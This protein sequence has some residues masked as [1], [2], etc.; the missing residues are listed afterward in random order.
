MANTPNMPQYR[1]QLRDHALIPLAELPRIGGYLDGDVLLNMNDVGAFVLTIKADQSYTIPRNLLTAQQSDIEAGPLGD[2]DFKQN[3][4]VGGSIAV[5]T[6]QAWHGASS[7]KVIT[8]GASTFQSVSVNLPTSAFVAG[9]VYTFSGYLK[10]SSGTPTL[11][12]YCQANDLIA[13]NTSIGTVGAIVLSTTWTRYTFTVTLPADLSPYSIIGLRAD[14]GGT[15]QALTWWL[16]GL[17]VERASSASGWA[18]GGALIE[19]P[20][21]QYFAAGNGVIISRD[22]GDGSGAQTILSGPIWHLERRLQDNVYVLAGPDDMWSL[23]ARRAEPVTS[24]SYPAAVLTLSGLLRYYKLGES[25]GTAA[26]DSKSA[27]SGTYTGGFTLGQSAIADDV[28]TSVLFNGT[29]GYVNAA[30]TSLPTGNAAMFMGVWCY[31]ASAPAGNVAPIWYGNTTEGTR[32]G[33]YLQVTSAGQVTAKMDGATGTTPAGSFTYGVPHLLGVMWDGTNLTCWLDGVQVGT[34]APGVANFTASALHIG[35][36]IGSNFWPGKLGHAI[37]GSGTIAGSSWQ[38]LYALGLSRYASNYSD[39][40]TATA[41]TAIRGY[42]DVNA[43]PSALAARQVFGLALAADPA[44]GSVVTGNE[45]FDNLLS[46]CQQ[47][48]LSGGDIGFRLVQTDVGVLTFTIYQPAT[49]SNAIFSQELGNLLDAVYTL[50]GPVGNQYVG[51]GGGQGTARLFVRGQDDTSIA[52]WGLVE[53]DLLD[54]RD[55]TDIPTIQQRIA[56]QLAQDAQQTNLTITPVDTPAL[57]FGRDYN[58]GDIVT[59]QID[60]ET[61]TDKIRQIHIQLNDSDQELV[62]PGIGNAGSGQIIELFDAKQRAL[63]AIKQ[64]LARLQ[65]AQ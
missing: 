41:S 32:T 59:V 47:L 37:V 24:F 17:Q 12:F 51:A 58:L 8:D 28:A 35:Q 19:V 39:V 16:D 43:G 46:A 53:A 36:K 9:G 33:L 18:L 64:K 52:T 3:V 4:G 21:S 34:L 63:N 1:I 30:G 15:P 11:R 49:Q 22:R 14:T 60:G 31:L 61:I 26:T 57:Q 48:A 44:I 6:S 62:S 45:R 25:S 2:P 50:D 55:T 10:A 20:L 29:S 65:A 23:K 40:R 42:V 5:D 54:A 13:G 27:V 56:A 38:T 7:L